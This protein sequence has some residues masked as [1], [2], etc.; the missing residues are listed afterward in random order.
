MADITS[1]KLSTDDAVFFET[2]DS[3]PSEILPGSVPEEGGGGGEEVP[4]P[5]EIVRLV[6]RRARLVP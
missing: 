1:E 5:T 2:Q 6:P 3:A 4:E